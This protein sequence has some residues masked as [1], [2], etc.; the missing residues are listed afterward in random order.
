MVVRGE[1]KL[2][3]FWASFFGMRAVIGCV[4][5]NR[6]AVSKKA[7]CLQ[8]CSSKPHF[9]QR[10]CRSIPTGK[11]IAQEAHRT[12]SRFPG[13]AGVFGPNSSFLGVGFLSDLSRSRSDSMYPRCPYLRPILNSLRLEEFQL[14]KDFPVLVSYAQL[15]SVAN[16]KIGHFDVEAALRRR[17][18]R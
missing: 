10:P 13:M 1:Y 17:L 11:I 7:H 15:S 18:A 6:L 3:R 4:H 2:Q 9:G 16:K 8:L 14:I 5:S 12:T